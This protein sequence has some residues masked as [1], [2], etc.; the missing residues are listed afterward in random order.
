MKARYVTFARSL[1]L[2]G[3]S[4]VPESAYSVSRYSL[5]IADSVNLTSPSAGK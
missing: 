1:A 2:V 3:N 5:I 4:L